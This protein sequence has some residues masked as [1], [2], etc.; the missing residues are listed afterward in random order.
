M[1][2]ASAS[3]PLYF[4]LNTDMPVAVDWI[5]GVAMVGLSVGVVAATTALAQTIREGRLL[6][7][8][9]NTAAAQNS[10]EQD[11]NLATQVWI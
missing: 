1:V 9:A 4:G 10:P 7:S 5:L 6:A 8:A 2:F 3:W 11:R